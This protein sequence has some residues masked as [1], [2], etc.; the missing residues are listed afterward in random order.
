[1]DDILEHT[2]RLSPSEKRVLL[3]R[4]LQERIEQPET[5]HPLSHGQRALWFLHQLAPHSQAYNTLFAARIRGNV[6]VSALRQA[7]Q[8][9]VNRH[10]TLRTT[11]TTLRGEPVQEV[12]ASQVVPFSH[13]DASIQSWDSLRTMLIEGSRC[14]FDLERGPVFRVNLYSRSTDD[15]ALLVTGHHIALDL[16]SYM[17]LIDELRMLYPALC[18][19]ARVSLPPIPAQYADFVHW[20]AKMLEAPRGTQLLAYWREQLAGDLPVLNLPTDRRRSS[21]KTYKGASY[22]IK[23]SEGLHQRLDALAKAEGTTLYVIMLTAFQALLY[24]YSGQSDIVVGSPTVGRSQADFEK[25]VG[26]FVNMVPLRAR[27]KGNIPFNTLLQEMQVTVAQALECQDYPLSLIVEHLQVARDP[28]RSPLFDACFALETSRMDRQGITP[29]LLGDPGKQLEMGDLSLEP[30]SITQQE[31]QFDLTLHAFA[32]EGSLSTAWQYDTGLFEPATIERMADHYL[33]ILTCL[34]NDPE[35]PLGSFSI[36]T[37][38]ERRQMLVWN[39]TQKAYPKQKC[40]HELFKDQAACRPDG[41]ALVFDDADLSASTH[42]TYR[43]LDHQASRLAHSLRTMGVGPEVLVGVYMDKSPDMIIGILGILKAGGA[44]VPF[45]PASPQ[46]RLAFMLEDAQVS[47]LLTQQESIAALPRQDLPMLCLDGDWEEFIE[48]GDGHDP[49]SVDKVMADN[50]AYVI[51][52]SGSTGRPKGSLVTQRGLPNLSQAQADAFGVGTSSRVLQFSS[53]SYDASLFE[54]VMALGSGA[55]LCLVGQDSLLL[56]P[57]LAHLLHELAITI[58]TLPPS[59]LASLLVDEFPSLKTITV[60][61]EACPADLA[62][63]WAGKSRFFNL[64]GPTE[65]TIWTTLAECLDGNQRPPIGHPIANVSVY[66]VDR[67]LQPVPIGIPGE[68]CIGGISV[69]RGYLGRPGLTAMKFIPDPFGKIPGARLYRTGDMARYLPNGDIEF[70]GRIDRQVKLRGFRIELGEIEAALRNHPAVCEAVVVL[71]NMSED[72][73]GELANKRLV[74]Y[75][76]SEPKQRPAMGELQGFLRHRLPDHMV[77]AIFT[78]LDELPLMPSG[79]VDR[80]ALPISTGQLLDHRR[81]YVAPQTNVERT[82]AQIWQETLSVEKVGIHDNF[83][84]LGGHSLLMTQVHE[85]LQATLDRDVSLIDLFRYPTIAALSQ[86]LSG[87]G[88]ESLLSP[89]QIHR[90]AQAQVQAIERQRQQINKLREKM[91]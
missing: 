29:F 23:L 79:K 54:I 24:C 74:A 51:Y 39:D 26:Y 80:R 85:R 61:G 52:T 18:A 75:V 34:T 14:P 38:A 59:A 15:Y 64:Y 33:T 48:L 73:P 90:Q 2:A 60:A 56:G 7:F 88:K 76:V 86:Y 46:E 8:T 1:M 49:S 16:W 6:D 10:A 20:Q 27:L 69:G 55:T 58:V 32:T 36:R 72:D 40:F 78:F 68:L 62:N 11:Y 41:T 30:I 4:L 25:V 81:D 66:L 82:V 31:G 84:D 89:K 87:G 71:D 67:H 22:W 50:L 57:V 53:L 42:L 43:A 13:I 5:Y 37:E 65:A 83:F 9:L 21:S 19:G 91:R 44:Y 70:L 77:P 28:G 45:D 12:H 35:Q 63:R 17:I 47:L 3:A